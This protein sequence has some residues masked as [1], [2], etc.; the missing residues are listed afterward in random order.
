MIQ[1]TTPFWA[2]GFQ[3]L[4][5][6]PS[7]AQ[8]DSAVGSWQ[9]MTLKIERFRAR[10]RLSGEL[11]SEHL[12]HVEAELRKCGKS[13]VLD[14]AEVNLADVEGVRFL[15][16]CEAKGV[17]VVHCSAY[18]REWMLRERAERKKSEAEVGEQKNEICRE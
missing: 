2:L 11:R 1:E 5:N 8:P 14:L 7:I 18:I 16:R 10:V 15:N 9:L 17:S 12:D 4:E 13:A 3:S 6:G